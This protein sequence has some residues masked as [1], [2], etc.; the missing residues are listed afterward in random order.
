MKKADFQFIA[1]NEV[2]NSLFKIGNIDENYENE[3]DSTIKYLQ[4]LEKTRMNL[5]NIN[6]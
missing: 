5:F 2:I 4:N 6:K 1:G 3:F